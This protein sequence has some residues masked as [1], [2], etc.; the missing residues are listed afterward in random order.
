MKPR[1]VEQVAQVLGGR[2]LARPADAGAMVS[3]ASIDTRGLA[4]GDAFFAFRGEH[5]DGRDYLKQAVD[6]GSPLCVVDQAPHPPCPPGTMLVGDLRA[7]L[8]AL[9]RTERDLRPELRVI[10]VTGTNGKTT[11]TRLIEAV[12]STELCGRS[13][14]KSFNNELGLPLTL[15]G[16]RAD[17][18]FVVCEMGTSSPGEIGRLTSIA[19]PDVVVITSIGRGHLQGL[20]SIEGV[21]QEKSAI[22]EGLASGGV[23]II[24]DDSPPLDAALAIRPPVETQR[25][26]ASADARWR[27]SNVE[28]GAIGVRLHLEG[29]GN[30]SLPL[31]GAHNA[32]NAGIAAAVGARLGLSAE[33]IAR[34]LAG[35]RGPE[36]RLSVETIGLPEGPVTLIND[37]YNANP[38]SMRAALAT[39]ATFDPAPGARRVAI[40]GD[41][42]ELGEASDTEH[43]ALIESAP[44][45]ID[46]ILALGAAMTRAVGS[47][48][49]GEALGDAS[50][51]A[52]QCAASLV[53]PGDVVL[54]KASRSMRLERVREAMLTLGARSHAV[55][56]PPR[57]DG[58]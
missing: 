53:R 55:H 54:L 47:T 9:A 37:A 5:A 14:P 56:S 20:G 12:L 4:A 19:R 35:A 50:D 28:S 8:T 2:W 43:A 1:T 16:A 38:D 32:R 22:I 44:S 46:L 26:G 41:M 24:T 57:T 34:G 42:L 36:M 3:G 6:L 49:R 15:L 23:A 51:E 18:E 33:S 17:D 30:L 39:L 13:S 58:P 29:L 10:G 52:A 7:A 31:P 11:T 45:G 48:P 25:V 40:L 27:L 21:A